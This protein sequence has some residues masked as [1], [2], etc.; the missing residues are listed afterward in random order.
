MKS[1]KKYDMQ[2][3][4]RTHPSSKEYREG[5]DNIFKKKETVAETIKKL[6]DESGFEWVESEPKKQL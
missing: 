5:W 4:I 6:Q 3:D 2:G 1:V